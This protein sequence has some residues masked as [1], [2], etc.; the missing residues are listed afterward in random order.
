MTIRRLLLAAGLFALGHGLARGAADYGAICRELV[1]RQQKLLKDVERIEQAAGDV[2]EIRKMRESGEFV[3]NDEEKKMERQGRMDLH[4]FMERCRNDTLEV[5]EILDRALGDG[6]YVEP[7]RQYFGDHLD[8]V[9]DVRWEEVGL[10][11]VVEDL[12]EGYGVKLFVRGEI[13]QSKTM[14]LRGEMTLLSMLLYIENVFDAKLTAIDG[15]LWFVPAAR[16]PPAEGEKKGATG[17]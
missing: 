11:Q 4:I 10:E 15:H 8:E 14:S 12:S 17:D 9:V 2:V 7:L 13:D 1:E 5:L 16:R 6:V 3:L